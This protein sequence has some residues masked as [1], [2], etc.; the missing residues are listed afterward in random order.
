M[1]KESVPDYNGIELKTRR[2]YSKSMINLFN[3]VPD[4]KEKL[5]LKRLRDKYGWPYRKDKKYKA[6]YAEVYGN[7]KKYAGIKHQFKLEVNRIEEKVYL[8]IFDKKGKLVEKEVY[9]SFDYLKTKLINKLKVLALIEAWTNNIDGWNYFKYYKINFYT[10]K[11]FNYFID[12][13]K[14]GKIKL[15]IRIDI[16]TDKD[17]YGK[18]YDHGCGFSISKDNL[19]LLFN[20]LNF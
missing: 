4:G 12:L 6:L 11:S 17:N 7:I 10:L 20:N 18:M 3:A 9:W 16:Y 13:I 2:T 14:N 15:S 1:N 5:E 8:C 19:N